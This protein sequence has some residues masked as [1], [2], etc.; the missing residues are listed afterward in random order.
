MII[1]L[2]YKHIEFGSTKLQ[3]LCP[4]TGLQRPRQDFKLHNVVVIVSK[5]TTGSYAVKEVFSICE[6]WV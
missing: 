6:Q 4:V 5:A 3:S 2:S 1:Y